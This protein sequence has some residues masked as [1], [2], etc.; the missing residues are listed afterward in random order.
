VNHHSSSTLPKIKNYNPNYMQGM[1]HLPHA[2]LQRHIEGEELL[3][4]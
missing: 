1:Q 2:I 4:F 3:K